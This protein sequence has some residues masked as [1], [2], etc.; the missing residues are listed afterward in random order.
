MSMA[1]RVYLKQHNIHS[2]RHTT[3]TAEGQLKTP[4]PDPY[5]IKLDLLPLIPWGSNRFPPPSDKLI[6][7]KAQ[8]N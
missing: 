7:V 3:K 5:P 8:M 4:F 1:A 2:Q 6:L